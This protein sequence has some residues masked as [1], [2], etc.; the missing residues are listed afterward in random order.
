KFFPRMIRSFLVAALE[1][2]PKQKDKDIVLLDPFVGSGTAL[3]EASFIGLNSLGIDI[4]P[5]SC[6]IS[7]AKISLMNIDIS[8][9]KNEI[10][11]FKRIIKMF[12]SAKNICEDY[13]FPPW[14]SKKFDT[15]KKSSKHNYTIELRKKYEH[16]ISTVRQAI[17]K[18]NSKQ[19]KQIFEISLSDAISRKFNIR[20]MGT[21]VG[22][23]SLEI[24]DTPLLRIIETNLNNVLRA[25]SV[26]SVLKK[27]YG[28]KLASSKV[29][30]DTAIKMP[31]KDNVVSV[32][33]TSP[34]YLPASSGRED[35]LISK[36]ISITALD[37]MSPEQIQE[38]ESKSVGSMRTNGNGDFSMLPTEVQEL[39]SWLKADNLR[40]IKAEPTAAYY[41][42][43]LK[44]LKESYRVLS[45][46]GTAIYVIGKESV[47][48]N[49]STRKVLYRVACD[50]IFEK[51]AK[52]CG[53]TVEAKVNVEL[54]KRNTN[55]RP[56]SLDSYYETVF[57]LRK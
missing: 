54:D 29:I 23:F 35:Y 53:F 27:T 21:G 8:A 51:I 11:E 56:R 3:V 47:F 4:D 30:N 42:S 55:A 7:N 13:S 32:I 38:G 39:Y 57:V 15:Q 12:E 46:Q 25:A 18:I 9:F 10:L 48:Y 41:Q 49:F 19:L 24:R 2:L 1:T 44:A 45:K 5:L 50:D 34:P 20:M 33:L 6:A 26:C 14:I 28:I 37:L 52:S 17:D 40:A 36:S 43:L 16:E 22:R 31:L